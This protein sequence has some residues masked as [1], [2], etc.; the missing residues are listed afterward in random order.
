MSIDDFGGVVDPIDAPAF[1]PI[2][3]LIRGERE[4]VLQMVCIPTELFEGLSGSVDSMEWVMP[5][6]SV[7]EEGAT[8]YADDL[9]VQPGETP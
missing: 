1:K 4:P 5:A 9:R 3:S 8:L 7:G 6:G 2:F